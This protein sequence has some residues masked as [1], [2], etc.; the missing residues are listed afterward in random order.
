VPKSLFVREKGIAWVRVA[1]FANFEVQI[2]RF[3]AIDA[4]GLTLPAT[5]THAIPD[6][7]LWGR[8]HAEVQSHSAFPAKGEHRLFIDEPIVEPEKAPVRANKPCGV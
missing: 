2:G 7:K 6:Q 8:I 1:N 5:P 4:L 3:G